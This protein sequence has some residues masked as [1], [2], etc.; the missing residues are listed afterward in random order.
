MDCERHAEGA[1]PD[2]LDRCFPQP[3]ERARKLARRC[4]FGCERVEP[5]R[6]NDR[7]ATKAVAPSPGLSRI[8]PRG[9]SARTRTEGNKSLIAERRFAPNGPATLW[10]RRAS[11]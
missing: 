9:G 2:A 1:R 10:P 11:A 3:S 7:L 8:C 6:G 5:I 4:R